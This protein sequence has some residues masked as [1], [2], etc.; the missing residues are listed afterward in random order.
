MVQ[1]S[2]IL[3]PDHDTLNSWEEKLGRLDYGIKVTLCGQ[4]EEGG[5]KGYVGI[6]AV[7]IKDKSVDYALDPR[8]NKL[9]DA[10]GT[11]KESSEIPIEEPSTPIEDGSIEE[12]PLDNPQILVLTPVNDDEEERVV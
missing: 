1:D 9:V 11:C 12:D 8:N 5:E 10:D 6:S 4:R 7:L 2:Q 3:Q